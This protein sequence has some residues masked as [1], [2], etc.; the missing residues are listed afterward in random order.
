MSSAGPSAATTTPTPRTMRRPGSIGRISTANALIL[1]AELAD[2]R[3]RHA[4]L[5]ADRWLTGA[6]ID[7]TG[8]PDIVWLRPD[9][10]KMQDADWSNSQVLGFVLYGGNERLC[11]WINGSPE[12]IAISMPS[13]RPAYRW[14]DPLA[15][16]PARSVAFSLEVRA[17]RKKLARPINSL[18]LLPNQ[19]E[20]SRSGGILKGIRRRFRS[21]QSA[22]F[23][24]AM[25]IDSCKCSGGD[26]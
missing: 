3:R 1:H 17:A 18:K 2:F 23:S 5:F 14:Q 21:R 8:I 9:G 10:R 12:S 13:N 4:A 24:T 22:R 20:F 6:P 19:Q 26:R 7:A 11:V 15:I 25:G 16:V